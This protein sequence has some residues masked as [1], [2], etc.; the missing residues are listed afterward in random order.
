[1]AA[2]TGSLKAYAGGKRERMKRVPVE[3]EVRVGSRGQKR[4][5]GSPTLGTLIQK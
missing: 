2:A 4:A 3:N 5:E 1:M